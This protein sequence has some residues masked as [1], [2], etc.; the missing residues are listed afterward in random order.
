M[1]LFPLKKVKEIKDKRMEVR[2]GESVLRG[3]LGKTSRK[4][5]VGIAFT[6]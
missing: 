2:M 5:F 3:G 6:G 1:R 4:Y